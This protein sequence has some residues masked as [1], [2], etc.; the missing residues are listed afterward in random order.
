MVVS[1][2]FGMKEM[3]LVNT[4]EEHKME[5]RIDIII[6]IIVFVKWFNSVEYVDVYYEACT[7]EHFTD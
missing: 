7:C 4:E 3:G 5:K 2:R 1:C 6:L